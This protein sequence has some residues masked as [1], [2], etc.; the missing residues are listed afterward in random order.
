M[1]TRNNINSIPHLLRQLASVLAVAISA[2]TVPFSAL[3]QSPSTTATATATVGKMEMGTNADASM[4]MRKSMED[5]QK[6]MAAMPATGNPDINFAMMMVAHHQ[7]AIDMAQ[8]EIDTGRDP[9][10]IKAAKKIISAQKK[11]ITQFEVWLKKNPHPM[12]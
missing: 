1:H 10:M 4:K 2:Y 3:A 11:E 6:K 12:K 5:M 8:A 9:A 7:G